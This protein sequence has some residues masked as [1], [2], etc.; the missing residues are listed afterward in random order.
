[1]QNIEKLEQDQLDRI[2]NRSIDH[3]IGLFKF[4][5]REPFASTLDHLSDVAIKMEF[6]EEK[7][8]D[9]VT[10]EVNRLKKKNSKLLASYIAYFWLEKSWKI[11]LFGKII[12][13]YI[14]NNI[15]P[16]MMIKLIMDLRVLENDPAFIN[17]I[18]LISQL[19]RTSEPKANLVER[20]A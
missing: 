14:F 4:K 19:P 6:D 13:M 17:S 2:L 1:M 7:I 3:K 11:A 16:S 8:K 9:N 10:Q 18:R 15:R 12:S 5:F 20:Q